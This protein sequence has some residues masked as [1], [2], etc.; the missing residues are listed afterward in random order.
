VPRCKQSWFENQRYY[1]IKDS[2]RFYYYKNSRL[3]GGYRNQREV[4]V[5]LN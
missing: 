5:S 2:G 3:V 4:T 1:G